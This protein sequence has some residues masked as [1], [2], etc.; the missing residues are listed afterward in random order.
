MSN[1]IADLGTAIKR[2]D[3][4]DFRAG[5]SI[6]VHVKVVEGNRSRVQVFQGVVIRV[7]GAGIGRTFTVRK[8]SFGVGVERTFPLHSPIFEKIEVVT[9]GDVRRAKLYYLRNLRGKAAKI[10]ERREA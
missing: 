5:D 6:K 7:Q 8:V 1:V 4:P 2:D 3:V 9:R 10:K